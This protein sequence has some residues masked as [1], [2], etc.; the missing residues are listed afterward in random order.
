MA[1]T[2]RSSR[3]LGRSTASACCAGLILLASTY[4]AAP[5]S[6]AQIRIG[7]GGPAGVYFVAGNAICRMV[8]LENTSVAKTSGGRLRCAAPPSGGSID[9]LQKLHRREVDFAIVQSDWHHH[10]FKGSSRFK[11]DPHPHLRSVFSLHVEP[12]QIVVREGAGISS[13]Q[14]LDGKRVNIGNVGSGH[15][16][17]FEE[18]VRIHDQLMSRFSAVSELGSSDQAS[19]LCEGKIDAFAF[20][21]GVPNASIAQATDG[22]DGRIISLT[23]PAVG[24]LIKKAGYYRWTTIPEGTYFTSTENVKTLGVVATLVT[25]SDVDKDIV[26]RLT[27]AV[28]G[29]LRQFRRLHPAFNS[30]KKLEMAGVGLS[31]PLHPGARQFFKS[32]KLLRRRRRR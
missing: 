27:K 24:K 25:R 11:G 2:E 6:L 4:S 1:P 22:C 17:T 32:A 23:T 16:A 18:L 9:N 19:A 15:R 20:T 10:A 28:F 5:Q 14:D 7:T 31:A 12:F 8:R 21:V 3:W 26:R 29:N 13:W 30:L